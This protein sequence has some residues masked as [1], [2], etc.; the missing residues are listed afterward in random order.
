[1][2]NGKIK[3]MLV[4]VGVACLVA[5]IALSMGCKKVVEQPAGEETQ[6]TTETTTPAE[7]AIEKTE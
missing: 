1:M 5:G 2:K 3:K 6:S 4:G 7:Q